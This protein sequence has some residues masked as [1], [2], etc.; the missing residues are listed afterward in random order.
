M[1]YFTQI[2]PTE[3]YLREHKNNVPWHRVVEIVLTTKNPKKKAD[4]FEIRKAGYYILFVIRN[5]ILY[6]INAKKV[7]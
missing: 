6:V 4:N 1:V 3:H 5:N 7:S 2:Q